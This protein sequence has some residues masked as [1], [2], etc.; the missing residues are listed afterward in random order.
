[1]AQT[2]IGTNQKIPI[3]NRDFISGYNI[4]IDLCDEIL[5]A[6]SK[7][8]DLYNSRFEDGIRN[9]SLLHLPDLSYDLTSRYLN[10]LN[11]CIESYKLQYHHSQ[12]CCRGP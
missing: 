1:M 10:E 11:S 9:Y 5:A 8:A 3:I 4:D 7:R 2:S 12:T 6:Q